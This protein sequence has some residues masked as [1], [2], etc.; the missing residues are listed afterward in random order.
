MN[1]QEAQAEAKAFTKTKQGAVDAA[2]GEVTAATKK[3]TNLTAD[4]AR[5]DAGEAKNAAESAIN[6]QNYVISQIE[7]TKKLPDR[8]LLAAQGLEATAVEAVVAQQGVVNAAQK[9]W[10]ARL[11]RE[12][13]DERATTIARFGDAQFDL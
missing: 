12:K 4:A 8:E 11:L 1:L 9:L 13:E 6:Y 5:L 10:D 3:L 7:Q 2:A